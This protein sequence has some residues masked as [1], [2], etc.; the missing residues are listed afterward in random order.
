MMSHQAKKTIVW[1]LLI[2]LLVS[3][4]QGI[5]FL[6]QAQA[7]EALIQAEAD[8]YVFGGS[9][10]TNYNNQP[11]L[12]VKEDVS[13]NYTRRAYVRFDLASMPDGAAVEQVKLRL[14]S[15]SNRAVTL[16][17]YSVND[18]AWDESTINWSNKP[19]AGSLLG[20]MQ[21]GAAP[22]TYE[23]DL[24]A[25]VK[26]QQADGKASIMLQEKGGVGVDL[27]TREYSVAA[28][29]PSLVVV[30]DPTAPVYQSSVVDATYTTVSLQFS[31]PLMQNPQTALADAVQLSLGGGAFSPLGTRGTAVI[32]GSKVVVQLQE[33]LQGAINQ[34]RVIAGGV[35]DWA[36]NLLSADVT[37]EQL[38][39]VQAAG[40]PV[41]VSASVG[42]DGRSVSLLFDRLI[43][44]AGGLEE[45][46]SGMQISADGGA[47][48]VSLAA[49][50][51]VAV[52]GEHLT[53]LFHETLPY[54]PQLI[55]VAAGLLQSADSGGILGAA[56]TTAP[57]WGKEQLRT[58]TVSADARV[59]SA[60]SSLNT[61]Y[62][63]ESNMI[64]KEGTGVY[65]RR[66]FLKFDMAAAGVFNSAKL[67]I[68][69]SDAA[70]VAESLPLY[71]V[72]DDSWTEHGLTY[73]NQPPYSPSA[74]ASTMVGGA[75]GWYEWDVTSFIREQ[76][77]D[78]LASIVL[79]G[80]RDH[81]RFVYSRENSAYA[82]RLI[83]NYDETP[84]VFQS[85]QV[86]NEN[87]SVTLTFDEP[88]ISNAVDGEALR[89]GIQ[90]TSTGGVLTALS[91]QDTVTVSGS[92][93]KLQLAN[94]LTV[95]DLSVSVAGS[96][97]KDSFGNVV[98]HAIDTGELV[99]DVTA[100]VLNEA[101]ELDAANRILTLMADEPLLSHAASQEALKSAVQLAV[102]GVSFN[103]LSEG[104]TVS[105]T[106][107][108]LVVSLQQPLAGGLNKLRIAGS[109]LKDQS[110]NVIDAAYTSREIAADESAPQL[111]SYY[112]VNFN[113][114]V[115]LVFDE[116]IF[117]QLA[118]ED[119]LKSVLERST[120]GGATYQPLTGGDTA[121]V[122]GHNVVI[123]LADSLT[124]TANR[125][126]LAAEAIGDL[127]GNRN[128]G[129]IESGDIAQ[130]ETAYPYAPPG[131][132]YLESA[133]VDSRNITF[134]NALAAQG[135][136]AEGTASGALAILTMTIA[137]GDRNPDYIDRYVEAVRKMLTVEANMPNLMG[138][139]DSR[140]QSQMVYAVAMLWNDAEVMSRFTVE[141]KSKLETFM[142][143]ALISTAYILN[144]YT[145]SGTA[146]ASQRV[147]VNGDT[148][149][150]ILPGTNFSEPNM[151]IFLAASFALGLENVKGILRS[152]DFE[153]FNTELQQQG[154]TA[155]YKSFV[156]T[157]TYGTLAAKAQIMEDFV[158]TDKWS[159]AGV[160]L[161]DYLS[162]PM[163]LWLECQRSMWRHIAE[164]G[165]YIGQ[166][167]MG[168]EFIWSDAA[169]S[170]QS[171]SYVVLG[172][173][174][175]LLNRVLVAYYG[176]WSAPGNEAMKAEI[177]SLQKAGVSDYYAKVVNGYY[178]Q[179][180]MG[181]H[182]EYLTPLR[183]FVDSM[184]SLGLL[185]P[186][187]FNDTFNY[188]A[189]ALT[190]PKWEQAGGSWS[191]VK[192]SIIPYNTKVPLTTAAGATPV[193]PEEKVLRQTDAA[194]GISLL[195]SA[196]SFEDV[197]HLVWTTLP[198]SGE[199][200]LAGRAQDA[201]HYYLLAYDGANAV[202]SK[203][204]GA[205]RTVLASTPLTLDKSKAHR[206]RGVFKGERIELYI[207]GQKAAEA[208]D[209]ANPFL[210]G[211]V[212]LYTGGAAASFD[213]VLVQYATP[214]S[215]EIVS[216]VK[217][218]GQAELSFTK[219]EEAMM[220]TIHY[221]V[222]PGVYTHAV[223]TAHSTQ[224]ITGLDNDI[225]YYFTVTTVS[226]SGESVY[227]NEVSVT[228]RMPN[229]VVPELQQ[230]ITDGNK[231]TVHFTTDP[232]NT[233]YVLRIGEAPGRYKTVIRGIS[234]PGYVA[235][236][237]QSQQAYYM[238]V[239]GENEFGE[240]AFS[241]ELSVMGNG[242]LLFSD[243][244]ESGQVGTEW[245]KSLGNF[246]VVEDGSRK[247][248]MA[249]GNDPDRMWIVGGDNRKNYRVSVKLELPLNAHLPVNEAYIMGRTLDAGNY[250]ILGLKKDW[251]TGREMAV[252]RKKTGGTFK[253]AWDKIVDYPIGSGEHLLQAEFSGQQIRLFVDGALVL[254]AEDADLA[255]GSAGLLSGRANAYF[256]DFKVELLDGLAAPVIS[257]VEEQAFGAGQPRK[258]KVTFSQV[259]GAEGYRIKSANEAGQYLDERVVQDP[260]AVEATIAGLAAGTTYKVAV[261]AYGSELEGPNSEAV[262]VKTA[263]E[264]GSPVP[265]Y[266][267]MF[268]S[269]GGSAVASA[270]QVS[271]GTTIHAPDAPVLSGYTFTGWYTDTAYTDA[272]DFNADTITSDTTLYAKWTKN[273]SAPVASSVR[274]T[275]TAQVGQTLQGSYVYEDEDRD[276]EGASLLQWYRSDDAA[277][278]NQ[279]AIAGATSLAYLLSAA[280]TGKYISFAVTPV[281]LTGT[282]T[283]STVESSRSGAVAAASSHP[284]YVSPP[285]NPGVGEEAEVFV[286]GKTEQVGSTTSGSRNGQT[287]ITLILDRQKMANMLDAEGNHAVV[288]IP[289]TEAANI[290]V[291]ELNGQLIKDMEDRQATL[292]IRTDKATY[293]LPAAQIN[294]SAVSA[295]LGSSVPL[296]DIRIRIEIAEPT[297][298][299]IKK[300]EAA[301]AQGAFTL[302]GMP[303]EF[304]VTGTSGG[305]TVDITSFN[306]YVERSIVLEEGVD[307]AQISTAVII[308]PDG[309]ARHVPTKAALV[310]GRYYAV[311]NSLT[312]SM[313]AVVWNPREFA[314]AANHWAKA[315]IHNMGARMVIDGTGKDTFS[316]DR[317]ITRAEFAA[318]I[319]RGLGL[320]PEAGKA[321]FADVSA[322]DW[323]SGAIYT[324]YAHDLIDGFA[325]GTFR[326]N[327]QITREQAMVVI[328]KAIALT[329]LKDKPAVQEAAAIPG[330]YKDFAEVSAWA[331]SN[332]VKVVQS[333]IVTGRS[334]SMLA[335]HERITRA[336]VAA[337]IER[338]LLKAG[339]I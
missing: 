202:I 285:G 54:G 83:L 338:L 220:Y 70:T 20:E 235:E 312:N 181:T 3:G 77:A 307:P 339:L 48:Y 276:Q 36:G 105:L 95:P 292:V 257:S 73:S 247:R 170:R 261:S 290:L 256:D 211:R 282:T 138:G 160:G 310:N 38:R 76:K 333:G 273:E 159:F 329:P 213:G 148:N 287:V 238:A 130:A 140:Q 190:A 97:L 126:R 118:G 32:D 272:W 29:R 334:G 49:G 286:N 221:G 178:A 244:F 41:Y 157:L 39:G 37:T 222:E 252:I 313:Y 117:S 40:A 1:T 289:F 22:G 96:L 294:I 266:T 275:G 305:E 271:A 265:T 98:Q 88:I 128:S 228:P 179:S 86:S 172:I 119:S 85:A 183:Y 259:P 58:V 193:D 296:Q 168:Q 75:A 171:S 311:I 225:A 197:Q 28:H 284:V 69:F 92:Q 139:L 120:D 13:P 68:Y 110:G 288:T 87:T 316:P 90:L 258:A 123:T 26:L 21:I 250:Y 82:P 91:P 184:I 66:I 314:D 143:A 127:I 241:N 323:Y 264:P 301:A 226:A 65:N 253:T 24:T 156:S 308:E 9:S 63:S 35:S 52:S 47:S 167:G 71:P 50:D 297:A 169:G 174:P 217:G 106:G 260:Q 283:G 113:K 42:E 332:I 291:S 304:K 80:T 269:A 122:S 15:S 79:L 224:V 10:S 249:D 293:T 81:N 163:K 5:W 279:T 17:V 240:S 158:R 262:Q 111:Q 116:V 255:T 44:A 164:D 315:S 326:P 231:V 335:P 185:N 150:W 64:L 327:E 186:A 155:I 177:E 141:E 203:Q 234:G 78:G 237:P 270:T 182:M 43:E 208:V 328:A 114:K 280:D 30:T 165:D 16:Q 199:V 336:E 206:L 115:V 57:L 144:D 180:W 53:I 274:F 239:S 4:F 194:S 145:G 219:I 251:A 135:S 298:D 60:V 189:G 236:L 25:Y 12:L 207:D 14:T 124:G 136:T 218:D 46:K 300:A 245:F 146:R 89:A 198:Q 254:E 137:S 103:A 51:Q 152:Y 204:N 196:E 99:Y 216:A 31:K 267:V 162:N 7:G 147:A 306:A 134:A 100:P 101:V 295:Q 133:M 62:G 299:N 223:N 59:D 121:G 277:G 232:V 151:T 34:I 210:S 6:D 166:P 201:S 200:G 248:I 330:A 153:D 108:A 229:A 56:V 187:A 93:L 107:G 195:L 309:T 8:S 112:I 125:F 131:E 61:N 209:S 104:D 337:I 320:K 317:D 325:D 109:T 192:D 263:V 281:A 72:A 322:E 84:P 132:D 242:T 331:Q 246:R 161:D 233:A 94:R 278:T 302:L 129:P 268:D 19:A 191:V 149:V 227:S 33:P 324:A 11:I 2:S 303:L 318:M 321:A 67:R 102:D 212:G 176:Y 74:I 45:L 142:K 55:R 27:R 173:D 18:D 175:S 154:L 205:A 319:V 188:D 214:R 243:S 215:P 23:I 230:L